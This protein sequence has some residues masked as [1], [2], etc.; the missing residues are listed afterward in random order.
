MYEKLVA[1]TKEARKYKLIQLITG[2]DDELIISKL[3]AF[4]SQISED[5]KI[6]LN[7]A[8]PP[9]EKVNID[10]LITEQNYKHPRPGEIDEIIKEADIEESIEELLEM[11]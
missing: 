1:M 7:V 10:E 6:L 2:I 4:L 11:I 3:E 8:R 5:D 9:R